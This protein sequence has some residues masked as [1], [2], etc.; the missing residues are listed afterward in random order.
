MKK[1]EIKIYA[2]GNEN[3]IVSYV[4]PFTKIKTRQ[5]FNTYQDAV[6]YQN[7]LIKK[8]IDCTPD[9][10]NGSST[11]EELF[12]FYESQNPTKELMHT[13]KIKLD[14]L[15]LFGVAPLKSLSSFQLSLWI[16]QICK[17]D[18]Y[19]HRTKIRIRY[20]LNTFYNFLM[21]Y[22]IVEKSP[23]KEIQIKT[24]AEEPTKRTYLTV[25]E[26]ETIITE[27]KL[28][29][30]GYFYPIIATA[31]ETLMRPSELIALAW[32][33]IDLDNQ[34]VTI[35]ET[36]KGT[37]RSVKISREL[38]DALILK[39]PKAGLVFK[40][41]YNQPFTTKKLTIL[42]KNFKKHSSIKKNWNQYDLRH[43]YA[44]VHLESKKS[45]IKLQQK[46]GHQSVHTTRQVYGNFGL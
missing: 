25:T 16:E 27:A 1:E 20:E 29:S 17:E 36:K 13:K 15:S 21:K 42:L 43:S 3:F 35:P 33:D 40:N 38:T 31:W 34:L 28:I 6:D 10:Y 24:P 30:P 23:I 9:T 46:L 26:I 7:L 5:F 22:H 2:N 41:H 8:F 4:H 32:N 11:F 14:F 18:Y 44:K 39:H 19:S 45:I 12:A 37:K